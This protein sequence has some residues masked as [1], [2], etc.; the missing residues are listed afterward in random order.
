[1][2]LVIDVGN[3]NTLFAVFDGEAVVGQWRISTD[4]RRTADEYGVWL[5]QLLERSDLAKENI[6]QAIVGSVVPQALFD[7][8]MLCKRYFNCELM[9]VGD[10]NVKPG[11]PIKIDRP[12]EVGA[13]RVV[14]ALAA[15]RRH[16]SALIVV[17]FG[18]ATTFDVVNG[19]GEYIGGV[20]APGI[21]L[22]LEALHRAAA[23]LPNVGILRP[24][25]VIGTNTVSAMQSGIYFG[26]VGLIEGIVSRIRAEYGHPMQVIATG[27]LAPLYAK[28]TPAIEHL[29]PDLTIFGLKHIFELNQTL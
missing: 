5:L 1:M 6:T 4:A 24:A 16:N 21:N 27:G 19:K 17:D 29:E 25:N 13:D 7:L 3:T 28:A 20:I 14:N 26:Y 9:I 15:W 11:I 12:Q 8:R 22:S 10:V 18:T 23:K 2:L